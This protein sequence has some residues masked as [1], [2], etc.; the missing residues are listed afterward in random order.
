MSYTD[1]P[2]YTTFLSNTTNCNR[3]TLNEVIQDYTITYARN[4]NNMDEISGCRNVSALAYAFYFTHYKLMQPQYADGWLV[5]LIDS[6]LLLRDDS[7]AIPFDV[8]F[9]G[10]I[11]CYSQNGSCV[12]HHDTTIQ[13]SQLLTHAKQYYSHSAIAVL[14]NND[15]KVIVDWNIGQF[16]NLKKG[17]FVFLVQS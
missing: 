4:K 3:M 13:P 2:E 11:Q 12:W 9:T 7:R 17:Q 6:P 10:P 14:L 16:K 8:S 5:S 15:E 1:I